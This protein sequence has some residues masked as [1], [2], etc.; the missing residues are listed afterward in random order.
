MQAVAFGLGIDLSIISC[1][2]S[3]TD[4]VPNFTMT[5]SS[6]TSEAVCQAALNACSQLSAIISKY[7]TAGVKWADAIAA[8]SAANENLNVTGWYAPPNPK[9]LFSYYVYGAAVTE[10][11]VDV[12]TG[13]T[14]VLRTDI[15]YD[16]GISLNPIIDIGQIEGAFVQGIGF[17][18]TEECVYDP[19]TGRLIN[20]GTWDYKPPSSQDIPIDFR[21]TLLSNTPNSNG[22]LR[23][24]GSGEPPYCLAGSV[25]FA[26]QMAVAAARAESQESDFVSLKVPATVPTIQQACGVDI[27]QLVV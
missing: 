3:S 25:L 8:A 7:R 6:T 20:N 24:K 16:A 19:T 14:H 12:L 1:R 15:A 23:S 21:V 4:K 11:L 13:E 22:I 10:V 27:S 5:G 9:Y 17:F 18:L 2:P 26:T